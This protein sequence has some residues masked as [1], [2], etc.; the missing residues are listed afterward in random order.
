MQYTD[1]LQN[2]LERINFSWLITNDYPEVR[3]ME[4]IPKFF[5]LKKL[6]YTVNSYF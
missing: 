5:V 1:T 6:S 3:N 2:D 4:L